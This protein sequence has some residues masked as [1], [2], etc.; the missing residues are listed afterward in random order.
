VRLESPA[1]GG[2]RFVLR[3]P[4]ATLPLDLEAGGE[5]AGLS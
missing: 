4:V 2:S 5:A 3:L 1:D